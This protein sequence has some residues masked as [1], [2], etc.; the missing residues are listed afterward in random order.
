ML[1]LKKAWIYIK[2]YWWFPLG[3]ISFIIWMGVRNNKNKNDV[4]KFFK[5]Y[6]KKADTEL[7]AAKNAYEEEKRINKAYNNA[8]KEASEQQ[9]KNVKDIKH[10]HK[11]ELVEVAKKNR[12][13][14]KKMAKEL[15]ERYGLD[16]DS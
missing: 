11:K 12:D 14:K 1:V 10:S 9:K 5:G 4:A 8:L 13:N 3:A 15:A 6:K 16:Y 7:S 2:N